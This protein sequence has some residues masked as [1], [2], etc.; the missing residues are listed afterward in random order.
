MQNGR[1]Q[2]SF[3]RLSAAL[4]WTTEGT[5]TRPQNALAADDVVGA[6]AGRAAYRE[7]GPGVKQR[8]CRVGLRKKTNG[9]EEKEEEEA[10]RRSQKVD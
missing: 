8:G 1:S 7:V 5:G 4:H 2:G 9:K 3:E 10:Q 6:S